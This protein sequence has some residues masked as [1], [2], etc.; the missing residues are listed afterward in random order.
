MLPFTRQLIVS[1]LGHAEHGKKPLS[2]RT[3]EQK[4]VRVC[5]GVVQVGLVLLCHGTVCVTALLLN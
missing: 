1:P 3:T 5:A 2:V 4:E